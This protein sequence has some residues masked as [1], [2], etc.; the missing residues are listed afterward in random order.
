[1][2]QIH[3]VPNK[4]V[5]NVTG[6]SSINSLKYGLMECDNVML[7]LDIKKEFLK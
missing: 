5:E 7:K 6:W 3:Q 1:M 4:I 2:W